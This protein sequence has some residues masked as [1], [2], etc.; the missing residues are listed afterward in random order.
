ML[1]GG[2]LVTENLQVQSYRAASDEAT[3]ITL[4]VGA[5]SCTQDVTAWVVSESPD[6]VVVDGAGR[7]RRG[8]P[9]DAALHL[10]P[11]EVTLA[12]PIG[13]RAVRDGGHEAPREP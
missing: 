12:A 3:T 7:T 13:D 8:V 11:F 2:R 1:P 5:G 9:C 6:E 4:V 10:L